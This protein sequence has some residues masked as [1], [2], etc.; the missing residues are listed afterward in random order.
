MYLL[1]SLK[2][3]P[4]VFGPLAAGLV[5]RLNL[6]KAIDWLRSY[7]YYWPQLLKFIYADFCYEYLM[8]QLLIQL[9]KVTDIGKKNLVQ[10]NGK[11]IMPKMTMHYN[12]YRLW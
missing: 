3:L 12:S 11:K 7:M 5:F 4:L 2:N 1:C 6:K 8:V 10:I 9:L